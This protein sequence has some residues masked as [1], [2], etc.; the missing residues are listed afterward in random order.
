MKLDSYGELDLKKKFCIDNIYKFL[1]IYIFYVK[2]Y[3]EFVCGN[4]A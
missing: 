3:I 2:R 1:R 4:D